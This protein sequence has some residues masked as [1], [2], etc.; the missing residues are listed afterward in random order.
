[1]LRR[2]TFQG[3]HCERIHAEER[4]MVQEQVQCGPQLNWKKT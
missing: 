4:Q 2:L 3:M 1:M